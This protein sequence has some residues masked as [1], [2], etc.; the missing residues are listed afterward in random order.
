MNE[1]PRETKTVYHELPKNIKY[2][3]QALQRLAN[4]LSETQFKVF[5]HINLL[6]CYFYNT[7]ISNPVAVALYRTGQ[8]SFFSYI[9]YNR[10]NI[11]GKIISNSLKD[12]ESEYRMSAVKDYLEMAYLSG[13]HFMY[14]RLDFTENISNNE[15][16]SGQVNIKNAKLYKAKTEE[17]NGKKVLGLGEEIE[18]GYTIKKGKEFDKD[19]SELFML[20]LEDHDRVGVNEIHIP[21]QEFS[22]AIDQLKDDLYVTF[23]LWL[24]PDKPVTRGQKLKEIYRKKSYTHKYR[25]KQQLIKAIVSYL[26]L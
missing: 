11:S 23:N 7:D 20:R 25:K 1:E 18:E 16:L 26:V 4:Q 17:H 13:Q 3:D 22:Q 8:L 5:S 2:T 24:T 9:S 14:R 15:L 10:K 6:T 12:L 19:M 21:R